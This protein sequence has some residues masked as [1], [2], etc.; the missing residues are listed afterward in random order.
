M[1]FKRLALALRQAAMHARLTAPTGSSV[2]AA[3]ASNGKGSSRGALVSLTHPAASGR[4][5]AMESA[6]S[7]HLVLAQSHVAQ[8]TTL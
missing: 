7:A 1:L 3:A 5:A 8:V 2:A 4:G 6:M